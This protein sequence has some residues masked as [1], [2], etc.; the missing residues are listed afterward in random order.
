MQLK[1]IGE[2]V[3][4]IV[5]AS[6]G[7]GRQTALECARRGARVVVAARGEAGLRSLVE[8]IEGAGGAATAVVADVSAMEQVAAIAERAVA[9]YGRIDTWVNLAAVAV[10]ATFEQ[11]SPEEFRRV[12]EVNLL[13]QVFGAMVAL[14]HLRRAGGALIHVSSVEAKRAFPYHS[15]YAASKHGVHG[16]VEALRVELQHEN[17]PVSVTEIL[18]A[19]VNT[20]FFNKARTRL[21]VKPKG[22]PPIYQPSLVAG[23]ILHAAERPVREIVVG[24][25]A[26]VILAGQRLAPALLDSILVRT[27]FETQKTREPKSAEEPHNLFAP[28]VGQDRV[29]GDFGAEATAVSPYTALQTR[30]WAGQLALAGALLI[31]AG[32]LSR[33]RNGP[34][35]SR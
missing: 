2:Q 9:A 17:A 16:F 14:P 22:V 25:A 32:L 6:S 5:G 21:G 24:D 18:P 29:E 7:I 34:R 12:V 10:Y 3:V 4:V 27:A 23:A 31:G 28:V 15:A 35:G 30:P 20:P 1:P 13:G 19:A 11:T 33:R 8:E 26:G